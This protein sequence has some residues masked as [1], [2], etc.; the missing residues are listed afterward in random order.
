MTSN[1]SSSTLAL[2]QGIAKRQAAAI[3][4]RDFDINSRAWADCASG[5]RA[6]R[7][8]MRGSQQRYWVDLEGLL[9]EMKEF[10]VKSPEYHME[11]EECTISPGAT[12]DSAMLHMPHAVTGDPPGISRCVIGVMAF[13]KVEGDWKL[14]RY[15]STLGPP[16]IDAMCPLF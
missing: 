6:E 2:F 13:E 3:N 7:G 4:A 9:N 15:W 14:V 11:L 8:G 12:A 10:T 16:G 5:F 1:A